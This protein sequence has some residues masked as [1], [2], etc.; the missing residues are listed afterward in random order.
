[1]RAF[2]LRKHLS[3]F[4]S[5]SSFGIP[6]G[7][8]SPGRFA[9]CPRWTTPI[10]CSG[11]FAGSV[12]VGIRHAIPRCFSAR[13]DCPAPEVIPTESKVATAGFRL[14]KLDSKFDPFCVA[15]GP[16]GLR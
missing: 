4:R 6:G 13:E 10:A 9:G 15:D 7:G 1:M 5:Q 2:F 3:P 8:F 16:R 14:A 11:G 12:R